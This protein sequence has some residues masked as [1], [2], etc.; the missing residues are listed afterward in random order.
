MDMDQIELDALMHEF[1]IGSQL[2]LGDNTMFVMGYYGVDQ[3]ILAD[4]DP[5]ADYDIA[6]RSCWSYQANIFRTM[7]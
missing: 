4:I 1:P 3:L 6:V 2:L 7:H 5:R